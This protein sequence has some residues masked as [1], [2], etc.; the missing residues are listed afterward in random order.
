MISYTTT[1]KTNTSK[2]CL[3]GG[4]KEQKAL[5]AYIIEALLEKMDDEYGNPVDCT[6]PSDEQKKLAAEFVAGVVSCYRVWQYD[7]IATEE[8]DVRDWLRQRENA[9]G[10]G[11]EN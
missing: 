8:V 7:K 10:I 6:D 4:G 9:S 5:S 3:R 11:K 1:A 2:R